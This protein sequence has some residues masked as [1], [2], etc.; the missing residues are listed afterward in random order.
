MGKFS[1]NELIDSIISLGQQSSII[2]S[3]FPSTEAFLEK[4]LINNGKNFVERLQKFG[5]TEKNEPLILYPWVKEFAECVSDLRIHRVLTAGNAQCGKS[6]INTLFLV[7]FLVF[8]GLNTLWFYPSKQQVD[9]LVPELFGKVVKYY[10]ANVEQ[11]LKQISGKNI[12]LIKP[13]DRQLAS[14]FQVKG[15]TAIFSYASN[16]GR[17]NSPTKS[18]LATVGTAAAS[19]SA[20]LMFIDERSQIPPESAAVL[21]RR[22]DAGRIPT[23]P[24]REIGTF[25][26]G[27]GIENVVEQSKYHFYPHVKCSHCQQEIELSPKGCLLQE[28]NGKY[29]SQTGRPIKWFYWDENDKVESAF[30]G[31]PHCENE[32]TQDERLAAYFKCLNTNVLLRDYLNNLPVNLNDVYQMR[33]TVT[34][35]LSPL[36]RFARYNLAARLI[37]I[38]LNSESV[39]DYQQQVLGYSSESDTSRVTKEMIESA[40]LRRAPDIRPNYILAGVD[41]GRNEDYITICEYYLPN[42]RKLSPIQQINNSTRRI[43]Y[44]APFIRKDLEKLIKRFNVQMVFMDNEPDRAYA[45][46]ISNLLDVI[47]VDQK[48]YI[49]TIVRDIEVS[50]GGMEFAVKAIDNTYF[51]DMSLNAFIN[52][53]VVVPQSWNVADKGIH[54]PTRHFMSVSKNELD[55]WERAKDSIDDLWFSHVFCECAFYCAVK[56][57]LDKIKDRRRISWIENL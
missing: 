45:L 47:P 16:S 17:D 1:V 20:S 34:V 11:E 53:Q 46:D 8:T 48:Q 57:L 22:L 32:I 24:I 21:P 3:Y 18:G 6:L 13:D 10:V 36:L 23:Q 54:S 9:S 14:R 43:I 44:C 49:A 40:K 39:K 27:L 33:D 15:A 37:D 38:G 31:C 25:G 2:D 29:L 12:Q 51:Q 28:S 30:F 26:A 42:N 55:T 41:Q 7:D 19:V 4:N 56:G 5:C 35:H 52:E 50:T